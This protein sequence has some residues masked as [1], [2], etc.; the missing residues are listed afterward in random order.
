[1]L[2]TLL[3]NTFVYPG[4][5]A[6]LLWSGAWWL[7]GRRPRAGP[8]A[9]AMASAYVVTF[10]AVQG[11]PGFPPTAS[12]SWLCYWVPVFAL[13]GW[14][15]AVKPW[16]ALAWSLSTLLTVV[17]LYCLLRVTIQYQWNPVHAVLWLVALTAIL[18]GLRA[19]LDYG[20]R[21]LDE[22]SAQW[23]FQGALLFA[24]GTLALSLGASG[25]IKLAQ[26][27]GALAV[28]F[29]VYTL[30]RF[31]HRCAP[32]HRGGSTPLSFTYLGLLINGYFYSE[33]PPSSACLLILCPLI[34]LVLILPA[35]R[36][37]SLPVRLA[38]LALALILC[39]GLAVVIAATSGESLDG[40]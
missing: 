32:L 17:S 36:Q 1:M 11:L 6:C 2:V 18:Q 33:L 31:V 27:A 39:G 4:L 35:L 37:R 13:L 24:L 16:P 26:F 28:V 23:L 14:F 25:S 15:L 10:V 12:L 5:A 22:G 30:F 20:S 7:G 9:A 8:N 34:P 29:S 19:A 38:C 40:Y 3:L 21:N